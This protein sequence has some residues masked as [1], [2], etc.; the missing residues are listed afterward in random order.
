MRR[1]TEKKYETFIQHSTYIIF[2]ARLISQTKKREQLQSI[3]A[4]TDMKYF[5]FKWHI[6]GNSSKPDVPLSKFAP[7]DVLYNGKKRINKR[8]NEGG[9]SEYC[10]KISSVSIQKWCSVYFIP[11]KSGAHGVKNVITKSIQDQ[12]MFSFLT[13]ALSE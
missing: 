13:T 10:T 11:N 8:M 5:S 3:P 6:L 4:D 2:M 1:K 12:Q 7:N 9:K